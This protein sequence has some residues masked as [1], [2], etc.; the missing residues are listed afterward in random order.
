MNKEWSLDVLYKGYD[1][2]AFIE[3][4]KQLE[5]VCNE[6]NLFS[7][8]L[9]SAVSAED[10]KV[11]RAIQLYEKMTLKMMN[12]YFY[13]ELRQT[14]NTTD[15][16]TTNYINKVQKLDCSI[17]KSLA[18]ID[19]YF[20]RITD[21]GTVVKSHKELSEYQY[22]LTQKKEDAKYLLSDDVEEAISK[23]NL[24]A[25]SAWSR[26]QEYLTST[27]EVDYDGKKV[28]LSEIRNLAYSGDK[29]VRK[30]AYEAELACYEKIKDSVC[31]S[32][33]SIKSQVNTIS[34]MRGYGS[35]LDMTLNQ[36]HMKKSTLDAMF[37]ALKEYLPRFHE[38]L[39]RK[40]S[41]LG[42]ENG[43]PW[44]EMFAPMGKE[45]TT[46][47]VEEARDYLLK[48]FSAFSKDI[49]DIIE[50]AFANS[51]I[52]FYPRKGK[53]GGAFC[54]NIPQ[55]KQSRVLTNFDGKLTSVVTLAHELGHA[56]HGSMIQD[57]A[58]LNWDYS[59]PVAETA[60]TFNETVIMNAAI[61]EA[62]GEEKLALIESQLQD[63]TQIMCDIYSR[64]LFESAVVERAKTDFMSADEL[65]EMMLQAQK[66]AYGDGLDPEFLHPYMW[67]NKSHY[68]SEALSF[69]NFPYAF[70]GLF[71]R[72][73]YEKYKEEGD[74]F[75]PKYRA[76]LRAT[77]VASVEDAAMEAGVNLEDPEFFRKSLASYDELITEFLELTK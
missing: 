16:E 59:M 77:T 62:D 20:S 68:Y 76:L 44:F 39:R 19:R 12:L 7:K 24:S 30:A 9:A 17:T 25:G 8:D 50:E 38:Y 11:I 28:T 49:A 13:L 1:D 69:Y 2:P 41:L 37:T 10:N 36:A 70:G 14:T 53:V 4:F 63:I 45:N 60:S 40:A 22:F 71:A 6:I 42:Y 58:P 55:K 23:M 33:N 64:Y 65:S 15:S 57:H 48:H 26:L 27:V 31:F 32:L 5:E 3:D 73:L 67:V 46:F 35:V 74:S 72:G 51:W 61:N 18:V 75:M 54:E 56:Y 29:A 66:E 34:E 52:D 43:L 47:T 21:I